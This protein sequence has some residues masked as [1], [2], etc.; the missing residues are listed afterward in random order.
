MSRSF[1]QSLKD[2]V[3]GGSGDEK[4]LTPRINEWQR[5]HFGGATLSEPV[6]RRLMELMMDNSNNDRSKRFGA[7][8]ATDCHRQQMFSY[9]GL[10][11]YFDLDLSGIFI[12]GTWRHLRWQGQ[13]LEAGWFDEVEFKAAI[14]GLNL[15]VSLDGINHD[16][17]WGFELKGSSNLRK[18]KEEGPPRKHLGQMHRCM[19]A[20]EIETFVYIAE[21]KRTQ[22]FHEV[23]V[24]LDDKIMKEEMDEL[25]RLTEHVEAGTVP[26]ILPECANGK[27]AKFRGCP[28][29][30]VCL[31][32]EPAGS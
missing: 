10:P 30:L 31:D 12:D 25:E 14:P 28:Y 7:S 15:G 26:D 16:E 20:A 9:L 1:S 3:N 24:H 19:A 5:E 4:I 8:A 6:A 17:E 32:Y 21:D 2:A 27:G 22:E 18:I 11:S 29:K 13:G 23:V